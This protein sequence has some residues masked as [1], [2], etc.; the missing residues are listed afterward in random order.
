MRGLVLCCVLLWFGS[1]AVAQEASTAPAEVLTLNQAIALA[2][3]NNRLIKISRQSLLQAND[4]ILAA[5]RLLLVPVLYSIFVLGL[6]LVTWTGA[7]SEDAS[8]DSKG[9]LH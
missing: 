4:Q 5:R 3:E 6:K 9:E 2:E 7:S 8:T 1:P